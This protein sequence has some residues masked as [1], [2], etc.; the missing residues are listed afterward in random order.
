M[1]WEIFREEVLKVVSKPENIKNIDLVATT[2]AVQYDACIKRGGDLINRIPLVKGDIDSM[3][4][5]FVRALTN[6]LNAKQKYDLT[7]EMGKGVIKYWTGAIMSTIIPPLVTLEQVSTGATANIFVNSNVVLNPGIWKT[8]KSASVQKDDSKSNKKN[9]DS[10][11]DPL[12]S[13]KKESLLFVGDSVTAGSISYPLV[14]KPEF[15]NLNI[16]VL[17]KGGMVTKWM[18]DNL[19]NQLSSRT[20][21]RVY[22][23]GGIN[24]AFNDSISIKTSINNV[25]KM[26][27]LITA[28]GAK[29]I[30]IIG[31][32]MDTST[33]YR[34]IPTTRYVSDVTKYIPMIEKYKKYQSQLLSDIKN[35]EFI[36][37]FEI[38]PLSDGLHPSKSQ[39]RTIANIIKKGL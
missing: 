39:H 18:L 13:N 4:A 30:I 21:N 3:K 22:I 29:A 14:I 10:T 37:K 7:G 34:K 15:P 16:D 8:T 2:Y 26:V 9:Q 5:I 27:D 25:Q 19:P 28:A 24:D 23:Y 36:G 32:N 6:G 1:S 20:Y 35:A 17:A 12:D 11:A 31:Y 38:G 33:D